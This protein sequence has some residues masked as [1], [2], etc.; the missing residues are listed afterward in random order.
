MY[1]HVIEHILHVNDG[2]NQQKAYSERLY[3][4]FLVGSTTLN[5]WMIEVC[6][7]EWHGFL[8]HTP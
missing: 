2:S 7:H 8:P 1:F 6:L 3:F 5:S 4:L